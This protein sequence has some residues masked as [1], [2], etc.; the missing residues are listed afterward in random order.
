M[1]KILMV[2]IIS[3][4]ILWASSEDL[5]ENLRDISLVD[6]IEL[7]STSNGV[8]IFVDEDLKKENISLFIPSSTDSQNLL[9]LFKNSLDKMGF[10]VSQFNDIYY[11]TKKRESI[12]FTYFIKLNNDSK[13]DVKEYLTFNTIK[14]QYID[15]INSFIIFSLSDN[16]NQIKYDINNIDSI[17]KQVTL[18]FT[19]LEFN[20]DDLEQIGLDT[21]NATSLSSDVKTVIQT[22]LNPYQ[23]NKLIFNSSNFYYS[24]KLFD[25]KKLLNV[26]QNPFVLVQH[27]K[28][29]NFNAVT[30]MPFLSSKV[31]TQASNY[32]NQTNIDYKDVG[33]KINGKAFVFDS[34]V[35]VNLDLVIED[36]LSVVDNTPTTYK[37]Q[38]KNITNLKKGEVLLLSGINQTKISN[39]DLKVPFLSSIPYLGEIFK[40]SSSSNIN[41]SISIA[42]ELVND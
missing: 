10:T 17:K 25:E 37:R 31:V 3:F 15:S 35:T 21:F 28:D 32:S 33:L 38:V 23:S 30:N 36:I 5:N 8:N 12:Y 1:L 29:F 4:Q 22:L 20:K 24:L 41:S 18:K 40:Y 26:K 34:Y 14:F 42:V 39:T 16:I 13:D 19:I 6:F 9:F 27:G 11:L 2:F 7:V